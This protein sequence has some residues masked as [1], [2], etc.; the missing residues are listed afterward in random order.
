[1]GLARGM[2]SQNLGRHVVEVWEIQKLGIGIW[3]WDV[4]TGFRIASG[5]SPVLHLKLPVDL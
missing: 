4:G 5:N 3:K 1:M 2:D